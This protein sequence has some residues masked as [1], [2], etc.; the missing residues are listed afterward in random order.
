MRWLVGIAGIM[1]LAA[2]A[3]YVTPRLID[4]ETQRPFVEAE[5]A[6]LAGTPVQVRGSVDIALLPL[7]RAHLHRVSAPD[8]GIDVNDVSFDLDFVA[9]L[10]GQIL[11]RSIRLAGVRASGAAPTLP[12][13]L[14]DGV[15]RLEIADAEWSLRGWRIRVDRGSIDQAMDGGVSAEGRGRI[16]GRSLSATATVS[17]AAA[18]EPRPLTVTLT[19]DGDQRLNFAGVSHAGEAL[20]LVGRLSTRG[21]DL[22]GLLGRAMFNGLAWSL[23][24][25]TEIGRE[26]IALNDAMA[27][28]GD[29]SATGAVSWDV[30]EQRLNAIVQMPRLDLDRLMAA[31]GTPGLATLVPPAGSTAHLEAEVALA[32]LAGGI[33]QQMR[34]EANVADGAL[35]I[36]RMAALLPGGADLNLTGR[37][38]RDG[39]QPAFTG[40]FEGVADNARALF[41]WA[42]I[43]LDGLPAARLRRVQLGMGLRLTDAVAELTDVDLQFDGTK[44]AGV[45]A[46]ALRSRPSFSL[47]LRAD[48]L[49]L[50]AYLPAL[51]ATSAP[52]SVLTRFDTNARLQIGQLSLAGEPFADVE[53]GLALLGGKLRVE[54]LAAD[55]GG[56]ALALAGDAVIA[57]SG[58]SVWDLRMKGEGDDFARFLRAFAINPPVAVGP[59]F[60][61]DAVLRAEPEGLTLAPFAVA[62]RGE[63]LT[64]R[65]NLPFGIQGMQLDLTGDGAAALAAVLGGS[66]LPATL[67]A[68]EMRLTN[69]AGETSHWRG[70]QGR[71]S[72][73]P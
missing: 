70:T 60:G 38:D 9:L 41:D 65:L 33:V 17:S 58:T 11:G 64:G 3:L 7:P 36:E 59:A 31:A 40:R 10:R 2:A 37:L 44:V 19:G 66:D 14:P 5:L 8:H 23:A 57:P 26:T 16:E 62:L 46:L 68:M 34:L 61:V 6:R 20:H 35:Q 25:E 21:R 48:R 72:P 22:G 71:L 53:A 63:T 39:G 24:A 54:R 27:T 1:I 56:G 32:T 55:V 15:R 12:P 49:N 28:L 29:T 52:L 45:A 67:S 50:D 13:A 43:G 51:L 47:D 18:G 30:R 73:V 42:G 4:Q 69:P